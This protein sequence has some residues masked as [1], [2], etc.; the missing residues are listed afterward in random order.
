MLRE[1][2]HGFGILKINLRFQVVCNPLTSLVTYFLLAY[3]NKF[4]CTYIIKQKE[5]TENLRIAGVSEKS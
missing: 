5:I 1:L 3:A 2:L 4:S